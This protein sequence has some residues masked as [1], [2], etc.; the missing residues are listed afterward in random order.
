[1]R[2]KTRCPS[3]SALNIATRSAQIVRP[4]VAFSMLQ[5]VITVPPA[6]SS[7]APTL[8]CENAA[9]AQPGS[10]SPERGAPTPVGGGPLSFAI[11]R[12]PR[13]GG[14][15]GPVADGVIAPRQRVVADQLGAAVLRP[16]QERFEVRRQRQEVR[17]VAVG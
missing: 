13:G 6:V 14:R 12:A 16:N 9:W 17:L 2:V 8:K 7:A 1:M 10:D 4:N 3:E 5:P 15:G 11:A